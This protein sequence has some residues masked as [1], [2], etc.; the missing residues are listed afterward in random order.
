[1]SDPETLAVYSREA[2]RYRARFAD[3]GADAH[4]DTFLAALPA[5]ADLLDLGCGPGRAAALMQEAGHRVIAY[6]A[7][8]EFV[9]QAGALGVDARLARFDDLSA[10]AAFD[11]IWANFSLLH[12]PRAE[13][14]GHLTAIA[15]ALRPGGV[16]H[17][18]LKLGTGEAR[19]ALGRFYTYYTE[20]ELE[21]LLTDAGLKV[22]GKDFG[23][24]EGLSGSTDPFIIVTSRKPADA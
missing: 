1:M 17:L 20:D 2:E 4:L 9:A 12:A 19:D 16:F 15:R 8:P 7:T 6:D 11:G 22:T 23:T 5:Q 18:G 14:P 3:K 10:L 24:G 21:R 13:M